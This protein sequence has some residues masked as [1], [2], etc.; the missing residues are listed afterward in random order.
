MNR[1]DGPLQIALIAAF[2]GFSLLI[3]IAT[4]S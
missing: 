2:I 1:H 3:F 4:R